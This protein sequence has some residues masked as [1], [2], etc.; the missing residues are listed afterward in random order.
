V[1]DTHVP[2][3]LAQAFPGAQSA[4]VAHFSRHAPARQTNGWQAFVVPSTETT[5]S[6]SAEHVSVFGLHFPL[7]QTKPVA[8]SSLPAQALLHDAVASSQAKPLHGVV[9]GSGHSPL[10]S[11]AAAAVA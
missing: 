11:H 8:Q 4:V 2:D 5:D 7:W 1:V 6:P 9:I 10:P 3:S